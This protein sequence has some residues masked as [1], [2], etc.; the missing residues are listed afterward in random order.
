MKKLI[1]FLM[2]F[3]VCS[4]YA[5]TWRTGYIQEIASGYDGSSIT[6]KMADLTQNSE[7]IDYTACTCDASWKK[8]CLDTSRQNFDKEYSMLLAAYSSNKQ[9]SVIFNNDICFIRAMV[10]PKQ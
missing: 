8:L 2:Y 9:V 4:S 10:I 5:N 6:F 7:E 3:A 1:Y